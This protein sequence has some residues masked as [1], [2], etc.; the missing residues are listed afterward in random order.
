MEVEVD[1]EQQ[2]R[3]HH[4]ESNNRNAG[5][6]NGQRDI[7]ESARKLFITMLVGCLYSWLTIATTTDVNLITNRVSYSMAYYILG[8]RFHHFLKRDL[9]YAALAAI[10]SVG[11]QVQR[12]HVKTTRKIGRYT[13][14][15]A[16]AKVRSR[17]LADGSQFWD[18]G[19]RD[20]VSL[21]ILDAF[22]NEVSERLK[23]GELTH[24][25]VWTIFRMIAKENR[26]PVVWKRVMEHASRSP[27]LLPFAVPLLQAPEILAAPETTVLAGDLIARYFTGF[28]AEE[29][30]KIEEAIWAIPDLP[31]AKTY[32][33]PDDQRN[34]LLG[35]VPEDELSERPKKECD[36]K[37]KRLRRTRP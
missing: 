11:A 24:E 2:Q 37:R 9:N 14:R 10:R 22:L 25:A 13:T 33:A 26:F 18:Q 8:V 7:S 1:T 5:L 4:V 36:S 31:L 19:Y 23:S 29:K 16:Y 21:Q 28:S 12:D 15:F 27:E 35:C 20:N 17:L 34:R 30:Q 32:R 6:D 3:G